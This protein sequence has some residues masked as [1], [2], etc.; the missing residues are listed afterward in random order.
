MRRVFQHV[1]FRIGSAIFY[2][3]NFLTDRD[4][5]VAETVQLFFG[6]RFGWLNHK[7]ARYRERNGWRMESIVHQTLGNIFYLNAEFLERTAIQDHF[8]GATAVLTYVKYR[9]MFLQPGFDVVRIQDGNLVASV[10]P[11]P[12]IMAM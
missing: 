9:V 11:S 6:F 1:V 12:P 2:F 4:H 3:L 5:S 7:S 10:K 8:V